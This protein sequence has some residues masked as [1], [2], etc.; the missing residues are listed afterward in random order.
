LAKGKLQ[1]ASGI[2]AELVNPSFLV[3]HPMPDVARDVIRTL[4][5]G[6]T[7]HIS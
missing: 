7:L 4:L 1:L 6:M 2:A 5:M 3:M